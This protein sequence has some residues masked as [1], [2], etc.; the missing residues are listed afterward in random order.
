MAKAPF[1]SRTLAFDSE[2]D[3]WLPA[4][5]DFV[6][7]RGDGLD[8]RLE[9]VFAD[10]FA[11]RDLP[12]LLVGMDTPQ[13]DGDLLGRAA[14]MALS[15]DAVLGPACDGGFWIVGFRR[16]CPGVFAGVPM[17]TSRTYEVQ[18]QRLRANGL[19]V[20]DLPTLTDV[21]DAGTA[22][23]VATAAP[24]TRFARTLRT[25]VGGRAAA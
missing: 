6:R 19:C 11:K 7:Q 25:I 18:L 20:A 3:G 23:E 5:F 14:R 9:S 15:A 24:D 13:L 16:E 4:G 12:T 10:V 17:S 8:A 22:E 1:A 21:D 2:P